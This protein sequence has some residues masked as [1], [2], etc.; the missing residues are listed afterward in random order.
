MANEQ[1]LEAVSKILGITTR[2]IR[3]LAKDGILPPIAGNKIDFPMACMKYIAYIKKLG[4]GGGSLSLTDERTRLTKINA[5]RKD[6]QLQK[7]KGELLHVDTVMALQGGVLK[8]IRQRLLSLPVKLATLSYGSASIAETESV[9][10]KGIYEVLDE[11][12]E[13]DFSEVSRMASVS[14]PAADNGGPKKSKGVR[15]GRSR[16]KTSTRSG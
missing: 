9:I 2:R 12:R 14:K 10:R 6:L 13:I 11:I 16:K 5:D 7:E 8:N 1:P 3:D 4:E 15:V